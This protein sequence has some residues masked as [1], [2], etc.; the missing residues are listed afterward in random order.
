MP[1][2]FTSGKAHPI[3]AILFA[4]LSWF[5]LACRVTAANAPAAAEQAKPPS[6][7]QVKSIVQKTLAADRDYRAG[8]LL[9]QSRVTKVLAQ[10]K[11]AGWDVTESRELLSRVPADNEFLVQV[12]RSKRGLSLM[13]RISGIT[14]G[15]DRVDNLSRIPNGRGIV[16]K[17]IQG[18]DGYKLIEYLA[19]SRGGKNLGQMLGRGDPNADLNRPTGRIYTEQQ[20]LD[21]LQ[22]LY[23]EDIKR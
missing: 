22:K 17:L 5:A 6:F 14:A 11:G 2:R 7:A 15:Y 16:E 10:L 20:L 13:R 8:D 12:L 21:A 3:A 18:P 4:V 23:T 9:C 1:N 19:D